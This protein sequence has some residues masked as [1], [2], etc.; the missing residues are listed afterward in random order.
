VP[1]P[2]SQVGALSLTA[3]RTAT[4]RLGADWILPVADRYV[5]VAPVIGADFTW[6]EG[7]AFPGSGL[8]GNRET[9]LAGGVAAGLELRVPVLRGRSYTAELGVQTTWTG[10][11][12]ER[13]S[14]P[15]P[16]GTAFGTTASYELDY[17]VALRF[18]FVL[19]AW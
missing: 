1:L 16:S 7:E 15:F 17:A 12:A 4:V 2:G 14:V 8:D 18:G 19:S 9:D 5:V 13:R 11:V 3:R 6:I 10:F